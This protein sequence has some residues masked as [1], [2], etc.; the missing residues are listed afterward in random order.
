MATKLFSQFNY[1]NAEHLDDRL[2]HNAVLTQRLFDEV[3]RSKIDDAVKEGF[4]IN[5]SLVKSRDPQPKWIGEVYVYTAPSNMLVLTTQ[6]LT[7]HVGADR[8]YVQQQPDELDEHAIQRGFL[9]ILNVIHQLSDELP[10]GI[11]LNGIRLFG[12]STEPG[13]VLRDIILSES[14][15]TSEQPEVAAVKTAKPVKKEPII[16]SSN[17]PLRIPKGRRKSYSEIHETLD[18]YIL[19]D[20]DYSVLPVMNADI[21]GCLKLEGGVYIDELTSV[22]VTNEGFDVIVTADKWKIILDAKRKS[23][24]K[25][26]YGQLSS[27]DEKYTDDLRTVSSVLHALNNL[28]KKHK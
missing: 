24:H 14:E 3:R 9:P 8:F 19:S 16:E 26:V 10:M 25:T 5:P 12:K 21:L 23:G 7:I 2:N 18:D 1:L 11:I 6:Y 28:Y 15:A 22:Q 20:G 27:M 4:W 17:I 13:D